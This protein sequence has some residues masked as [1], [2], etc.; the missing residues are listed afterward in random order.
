MSS[1]KK[2]F[3]R[4]EAIFT[5]SATA[6]G[7]ALLPLTHAQATEKGSTVLNRTLVYAPSEMPTRKS[8]NGATVHEGFIGS[9]TTG[10]RV[11]VHQTTLAAGRMPHPEKVHAETMIVMVRDGEIEFLME[12]KVIRRMVAGDIAYSVP[13]QLHGLRNAGTTEANYFVI[14]IGHPDSKEG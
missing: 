6:V 10:E 8:P 13:G 11:D 9:L 3:S 7:A 14:A 5:F 4:R 12:G 1:Q 2:A